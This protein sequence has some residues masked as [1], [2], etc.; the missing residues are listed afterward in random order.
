M[1]AATPAT[2]GL[3][4]SHLGQPFLAET[5]WL[6]IFHSLAV[7]KGRGWGDRSGRAAHHGLKEY[8]LADL[9]KESQSFLNGLW[10]CLGL[11]CPL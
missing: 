3:C 11:L 7:A 4:L 10:L 9:N 2:A 5:S 8:E 6:L 1:A